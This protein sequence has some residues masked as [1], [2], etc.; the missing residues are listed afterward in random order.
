L[1]LLPQL[2]TLPLHP[3]V[4]SS[5]GHILLTLVSV[6]L[7]FHFGFAYAFLK[8]RICDS[9]KERQ[10]LLLGSPCTVSEA[11]HHIIELANGP[12]S[13]NSHARRTV[14]G[15]DLTL[16]EKRDSYNTIMLEFGSDASLRNACD[17][18]LFQILLFEIGI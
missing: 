2:S 18:L 14:S 12:C 15:K 13:S 7:L 17:C 9:H 4:N 1:L 5:L 3:L 8:H 10:K 11:R 6:R 16:M